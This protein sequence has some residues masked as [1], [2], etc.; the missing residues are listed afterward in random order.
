[1][2]DPWNKIAEYKTNHYHQTEQDK[3][4]NRRRVNLNLKNEYIQASAMKK[5]FAEV[6]KEKDFDII[7]RLT[8]NAN[9]ENTSEKVLDQIR[10]RQL[11]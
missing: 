8:S 3:R 7:K 10:I 2:D 4:D 5:R 9:Q 1:M 11:Q 6:E